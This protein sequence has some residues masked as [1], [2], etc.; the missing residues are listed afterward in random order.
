[1][2]CFLSLLGDCGDLRGI[3]GIFRL[4]DCKDWIESHLASIHL[5]RESISEGKPIL[6]RSGIFDF[7]ESVVEQMSVCAMHR[8]NY[9]KF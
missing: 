9:G 4:L 8:H 7:D 1:M 2:S 5:S 6:A 3:S